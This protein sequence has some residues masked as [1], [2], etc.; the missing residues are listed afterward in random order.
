MS[1]YQK[2]QNILF[3][4]FLTSGALKV[5]LG[6]YN[7]PFDITLQIII[8]VVLDILYVVLFTKK[9]TFKKPEL[10]YIFLIFLFYAFAFVSLS[11]GNAKAV[12]VEKFIKMSI[13]VTGFLYMKFIQEIDLKMLYR[14]LLYVFVPLGIW[15]VLFRYLWTTGPSYFDFLIDKQEFR[16]FSTN[17]LN[18]GYLLG[19]LSLLTFRYSKRPLIV[20]ILT[21]LVIFALGSRGALVFVFL[22]LV[23]IYYKKILNWANSIKIKKRILGNLVL[24]SLPVLVF[25]TFYFD[26]IKSYFIYGLSRFASLVDIGSDTSSLERINQ[27]QFVLENGL[28]FKGFTIGYG[29]GSFG[30][31][32]LGEYVF[33]YP[34]N[35]FIEAWYE[36]GFF[37]MCILVVFYISPFL[38]KRN[39][40]FKLLAVFA[41]LNAMKTLS[42]ANDRNLFLL[43]GVLIFHG[44]KLNDNKKLSI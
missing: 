22:S 32:Y 21:L 41:L 8:L 43:L 9:L 29:L 37:A 17:Y 26:K 39:T 11:Y 38:L 2:Y 42:F 19:I 25:T 10:F 28:T 6:Y 14:V 1:L 36:M 16:S 34:H 13:P 12:G 33:A 7:Y 4:L 5:F 31:N 3:I 20:F 40:I 44:Y 24:I 30:L 15:F 27:Y 18:F 23:I 35:Q